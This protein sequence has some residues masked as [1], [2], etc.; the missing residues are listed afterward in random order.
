MVMLCCLALVT[1]MT[2]SS[3]F[4]GQRAS[5]AAPSVAVQGNATA[6]AHRG[7]FMNARPVSGLARRSQ[8]PGRRHLPMPGD[9]AQ[10]YRRFARLPL[11][12]QHRH[13]PA[14]LEGL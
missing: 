1:G 2:R 3:A 4:C 11:R 12:G 14:L 9:R 8:A 6:P 13:C 7:V 10:W 5:A